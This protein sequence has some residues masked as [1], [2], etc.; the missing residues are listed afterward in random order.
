MFYIIISLQCCDTCFAEAAVTPACVQE[1]CLKQT[2]KPCCARGLGSV[3][4][5]LTVLA[6]REWREL[7]CMCSIIFLLCTFTGLASPRVPC[8]RFRL[9]NVS[10]IRLLSFFPPIHQAFDF[11]NGLSLNQFQLVGKDPKF[12]LTEIRS[13]AICWTEGIK[14]SFFISVSHLGFCKH[15]SAASSSSVTNL[16]VS[17]RGEKQLRLGLECAQARASPGLQGE[18]D[19]RV[20][21][22]GW[23]VTAVG[24]EAELLQVPGA[25]LST[26]KP[27]QMGF[28]FK[29][30][31]G[32]QVAW[33]RHLDGFWEGWSFFSATQILTD[34]STNLIFHLPI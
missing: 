6:A 25:R 14:K 20:W 34:V 29:M 33:T 2:P 21:P 15:H 17:G 22:G 1:Q 28:A 27:W 9:L 23:W 19:W 12:S 7:Q 11:Y 16:A 13:F 5:C 3:S 26:G 4:S 18:W 32:E 10:L 30:Q 24:G 8:I 31:A